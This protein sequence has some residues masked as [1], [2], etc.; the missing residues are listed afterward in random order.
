MN[1]STS[2][3]NGYLILSAD[4]VFNET[5][6]NRS[7]LCTSC[8]ALR[9]QLAVRTIDQTFGNCPTNGIVC[10]GADFVSIGEAT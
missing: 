8:V 3:C 7:N 6:Q 1:R 9:H 10:I 4:N 5:H 2:L